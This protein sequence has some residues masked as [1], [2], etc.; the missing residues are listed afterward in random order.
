[1]HTIPT[2]D[3]LDVDGA[4]RFL[5]GSRPL[6][7][8]TLYRGVKTGRYPAPIKVGPASSRWL[9]RELQEVIDAMV[10]ERDSSAEAA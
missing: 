4:C 7:P 9:R 8:C 1:M 5:G 2:E 10:A 3:L 6:H